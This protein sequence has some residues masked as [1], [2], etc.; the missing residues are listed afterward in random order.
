MLILGIETSCDETSASIVRRNADGSGEILSNIIRSQIEEHAPYGGVVP[1]IA[2]RAHVELIDRVIEKALDE[3]DVKLDDVDGIAAT[4]GPGLVGG[5]IVGVMTGKAMAAAL[6]KPFMSINHLEGHALTARLTDGLGFPYLLLL[7]SGGHTQILLV[8]GVGDYERWASTLDDAL[9]EAFDKTAK[10][11]GLPYPGGP[12][13][14]KAAQTGNGTRFPLPRPLLGD[15]RLDFSFSGL[16]TAVRQ[17]AQANTPLSRQDVCDIASSFQEAVADT[18]ADRVSRSLHS[19]S[20]RFPDVPIPALVVAGGVAAN[21]RLRDVLE[22]IC[23]AKGFRFI[24]PPMELCTDNAAMIAWAGAERLALGEDY[25]TQS[26]I[27]PRWPL[28]ELSASVYGSGR[29]GAKA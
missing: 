19:F 20:E 12:E 13:V 21:K 6:D 15:K 11:L 17:S 7:V 25:L 3:A 26:Q 1:E 23:S 14:E 5:L 2:A 9:G 16:K 8:K 18:L 28:D 27:R 22:K 4:T 10:L 29:K 24:A